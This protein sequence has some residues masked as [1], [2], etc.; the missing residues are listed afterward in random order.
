M[1]SE[2]LDNEVLSDL[3]PA[4]P[5]VQ[6][7]SKSMQSFGL[8]DYAIFILMLAS[9][10][11]V[12]VYFGFVK[13]SSGEAEYLVGGRNMKT[14][15]VSLSLI[16]SFISGISLLGT[17]TE[18]YVHGVTY[19]FI[20]GGVILMGIVMTTV[21]LPVFHDLK[22]TSTYEYLERRFDKKTRLFGSVLF[23]IGIVSSPFAGCERRNSRLVGRPL[24]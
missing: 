14:F 7:V 22:L 24:S 2:G 6:E 19:L 4:M 23:T 12:G 1:A 20:G 11:A 17:P 15:P 10:G 21:Y 8:P 9:C 3:M 18:V 16:A 13:K 5:T